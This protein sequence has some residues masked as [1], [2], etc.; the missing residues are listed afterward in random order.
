MTQDRPQER[1]IGWQP[2]VWRIVVFVVLVA[3]AL[4]G[5]VARLVEVQI[6]DGER[7]RQ[8]SL[9]NQIRLI[10]VAAPRGMIYDRH[11]TMLVRS[12][13]SFVVGLIP[14]QIADIE[15]ELQRLSSAIGV[16]V[17][18]LR[19]RLLH[20][21][22]VDYKNFDEVVANEP[23]G[24]VVLATDLPVASIA[25]LSELL[26]EMPGVD[27]EVQPVRDYPHGKMASH[28]FGYVGAITEDEY[29][30]LARE[31]YSPN[32]VVG[33]DGLEYQYDRYLRGVPGGERVMVNS[34]GSVVASVASQSPVTGDTLVT[35][36]DW[37]LQEI[38]ESALADG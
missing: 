3:A 8:E 35:N 7:Y 5:L 36:L 32:D 33:K 37:R 27:L 23:Y 26:S 28:I 24:P 1:R 10:P 4:A 15:S 21:L 14:S 31:G 30:T 38:V 20:H 2:P 11:G 34:S 19:N 17:A 12:R 29:K 18:T 25:R 13:P 9:A 6:F 22:G 16:P